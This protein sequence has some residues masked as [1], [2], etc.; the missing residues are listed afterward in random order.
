MK[1][2]SRYFLFFIISLALYAFAFLYADH[3]LVIK[4]LPLNSGEQA[5]QVSF[6]SQPAEI[7]TV[8]TPEP[9]PE[10][11]PEQETTPVA[12]VQEVITEQSSNSALS[13][14]EVKLRRQ[15]LQ[16][17]LAK[18][19]AEST[20][21]L[22][23]RLFDE[24]LRAKKSAENETQ[25]VAEVKKIHKLSTPEKTT[26]DAR[27][28]SPA[29]KEVIK[30]QPQT[31]PSS[32]AQRALNN[33]VL[34]QAIVVSGRKPVYPQRAILRNQQGRVVVKLTV[35]SQ[36]KPENP[37]ILNSSGYNILDQ[38]VLA[39]INRELFMPALQG[40]ERVTSEQLFAFRFEL[41]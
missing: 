19:S 7:K 40:Q 3:S 24:Q 5:I 30:K 35:T 33:G 15:A 6:V 18:I 23:A 11:E 12:A 2:S 14:S 4:P 34:Q 21:S 39:F 36:G 9:E 10:P 29:N 16:K 13:Q 26:P 37:S 17:N 28:T 25:P 31:A 32:T 1:A 8:V 22:K 41:N 27:K 20:A 38:A